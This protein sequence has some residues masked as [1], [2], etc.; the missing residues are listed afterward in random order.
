MED[1]AKLSLL[2]KIQSLILIGAMIL[3]LVF[4]VLKNNSDSN[5]DFLVSLA[6]IVLI[7]SMALSVPLGEVGR[8]YKRV[9]FFLIAWGLNFAVIPLIAWLLAMVFLYAYPAI[10]IGFILYLVTP[11][12]DWFLVFTSMSKGDVPLGLA[13]LPTNLAL[14]IMLMPIYVY[15][16]AGHMID[17]Q[18][19]AFLETLLIFI[20]FPFALAA[21]TRY[22]IGKSK[23]KSKEKEILG[24]ISSP[25]Q[26]ASL[27]VVIFLMFYGQSYV[28]VEN[29]DPLLLMFVPLLIFFTLSFINAQISSKV[30]HLEYKECALLTCTT[31]ARNSPLSLA[32]AFGVFPNEP[33]IYVSIIIGVLIE[34]PILVAITKALR[35][36]ERRFFNKTA[37]A[38]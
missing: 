13:L 27:V 24:K 7:Y 32:I 1:E 37:T 6:I 16:F 14:Q 28:I 3:G 17:F 26:L 15:L 31:A 33:L 21:L 20:A 9:K 30:F 10:Y 25:L 23:G 22:L 34:L 8:S 35:F 4:G 2:E 12:T 29:L 11:C 38:G 19:S 5:V 36:C 18:I